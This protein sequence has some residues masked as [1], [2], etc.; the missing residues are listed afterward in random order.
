MFAVRLGKVVVELVFILTG[1]AMV[2]VRLSSLG[3][4]EL[5]WC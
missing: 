2:V 5:W 1:L 4:D 3:V